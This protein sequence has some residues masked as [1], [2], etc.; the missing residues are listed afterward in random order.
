MDRSKSVMFLICHLEGRTRRAISRIPA[1]QPGLA[2]RAVSSA[3][4]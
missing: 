1:G 2:A 3:T 4:Q